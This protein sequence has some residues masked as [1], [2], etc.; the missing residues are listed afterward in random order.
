V[1]IRKGLTS[2]SLIALATA[3]AMGSAN[4]NDVYNAFVD[5]SAETAVVTAGSSSVLIELSQNNNNTVPSA[6]V[7]LSVIGMPIS[8][9]HDYNNGTENVIVDQNA[10]YALASLNIAVIYDDTQPDP[11]D[12]LHLDPIDWNNIDMWTATGSGASAAATISWLQSSDNGSAMTAGITN[13]EIRASSIDLGPGSKQTVN[14][15][16][17]LAQ[18]IGNETINTITGDINPA[19]S[20][21]EGGFAGIS[22]GPTLGNPSTGN[23]VGASAGALIASVQENSLDASSSTID[24]ARIGSQAQ[25]VDNGTISNVFF[26]IARNDIAA[27]ITGNSAVNVVNLDDALDASHTSATILNGSAGVANEQRNTIVGR[28]YLVQVTESEIEAGQT[29]GPGL[30]NLTGSKVNFSGN[31]ITAQGTGNTA[32]NL[33][34]LG[35]GIS[36]DGTFPVGGNIKATRSST[37]LIAGDGTDGN[38]NVIGDLFIANHQ[39]GQLAITGA[40]GGA[41]GAV[42]DA[43]LN[44]MAETVHGTTIDV[45]GN[46]LATTV[47]G[48]NV[49]NTIVVEGAS[50]L[51]SL[52]SLGSAQLLGD[53]SSSTATLN[54]DLLISVATTGG[55]VGTIA[56][57]DITAKG[58]ALHADALGNVAANSVTLDGTTITGSGVDPTGN[59][60]QA[61]HVGLDYRTAADFGMVSGQFTSEAEY[62]SSVTGGITGRFANVVGA[63]GSSIV[64]SRIDVSGNTVSATS[65]A[66]HVTANG[67]AIGADGKTT[68]FAG[69]VGV[70]NAQVAQGSDTKTTDHLTMSATVKATDDTANMAII[71]I[72]ATPDTISGSRI[73]VDGNLVSAQTTANLVDPGANTLS[74][75]ANSVS[76][77]VPSPTNQRSTPTATVYRSLTDAVIP[78]ATPDGLPDTSVQGGFVIVNEQ[79]VEDIIADGKGGTPLESHI[80]SDAINVVVGLES[81]SL[82]TTGTKVSTS[83]NTVLSSVTG[84]RG[85]SS[86]SVDAQTLDATSTL[87]NTQT[88]WNEQGGTS[89]FSGGIDADLKGGIGLSVAGTAGMENVTV[90]ADGNTLAALGQIS[91]AT[92][93]VTVK[94]STQTVVD[95]VTGNNVNSVEMGYASPAG[96]SAGNTLLR[97][98]TGLLNSQEFGA[99]SAT[100]VDVDLI[101]SS[102]TVLVDVGDTNPMND[103]TVT[104]NLNTLSAA[105]KGNDA[106]NTL[107][108][109]V[110]GF[111]LTKAGSATATNGPLAIIANHQRGSEDDAGTGSLSAKISNSWIEMNASFI[112]GANTGS[113][114]SANGNRIDALARV[115][116]AENVLDVSGDLYV[117]AV[118]ATPSV[119]VLDVAA[120]IELSADDL[121]FGI[122]SYQLN[123]VDAS[124]EISFSLISVSAEYTPLISGTTVSTDDN[125]LIAQARG[126][127]VSNKV[128]IAF[129]TTNNLSGFIANLQQTDDG[130]ATLSSTLSASSTYTRS[131]VAG[132]LTGGGVFSVEGNSFIALA[133]ANSAVNS[134]TATGGNLLSG[135]R[136]TTPVAVVNPSVASDVTVA[137]DSSV[138]NVQGAESIVSTQ[139]DIVTAVLNSNSPGASIVTVGDGV[140]KV[141]NNLQLATASIHS[142]INSALLDAGANVGAAGDTASAAV[143]SVQTIT[144]GS[145]VGATATNG[146]FGVLASNIAGAGAARLSLDGNQLAA[147]ARGASASNQLTVKAGASITGGTPAAAPTLGA[148]SQT[149]NADFSVLNVQTGE[150]DVTATAT[151]NTV[152]LNAGSGALNDTV[153]VS[154]NSVAAA[155]TGFVASNGL[156]LNAHAA[157]DASGQVANRQAI[158]AGSIISASAS[159]TIRARIQ[160]GA[161][162]TSA[163]VSGNSLSSSAGGNLAFNALDSAA[164]SSLQQGAGAGSSLDPSTGITMTGADYGVLNGQSVTDA[165]ITASVGSGSI[166]VDNLT[167]ANGSAVVVEGNQIT[168]EAQG[169][170][171]R[172]TLSL[173]TGTFQYPSAAISNLQTTSGATISA[174][175]SNAS[176]GIGNAA[177]FNGSS[178]NS[179][180]IVRGNSIGAT[181]IGNSAVN[182]LSAD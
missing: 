19:F 82:S 182:S 26:D 79:S 2:V 62:V 31:T 27:T 168:A 84:N 1:N 171:A 147:V 54:G 118:A 94:A 86:L 113:T 121:A 45:L 158:V 61:T 151:G 73:T 164:G 93:T 78:N 15:N 7:D 44:V 5:W 172:N 131:F 105:A 157:S 149:V 11:V 175:V 117:E 41:A 39:F 71:D 42:D 9:A 81:T 47:T 97:A 129:G 110:G 136:L 83:G 144:S 28:T 178:T 103:S 92:N 6:V 66:N 65:T 13:S 137:A 101:N 72:A 98:E 51:N 14:D 124:A 21:T 88:F 35:D 63:A 173:D 141:D 55:V 166:L 59:F 162:N 40:I 37:V 119:N 170:Y 17:I 58:N 57:S 133:S 114:L 130:G 22:G 48:N 46:A 125:T 112:Q 176:I 87:V 69:T 165:Q 91:A 36:Q 20:S 152:D 150:T 34:R 24:N 80:N 143:V 180:L 70:I 142:A 146:S 74:I 76:D 107:T 50:T 156:S 29:G 90:H 155:A 85:S 104:A 95:V 64:D 122:A 109:D 177:V 4:A 18:A 167:S 179:S 106:A 140:V 52:V 139:N 30:D 127:Q 60:V 163:Q 153:S 174:S 53:G 43:N 111:D 33:V 68:S 135:T 99:L 56:N 67:F 123:A 161:T 108:L 25:A 75:K 77:A 32:G 148:S 132:N 102:I 23:A 3:S 120:S 89:S 16:T 115:N 169:N 38:T 134:F 100:G 145:S 49:T 159:A 10:I 12:P 128:T 96:F 154:G 116:E 160:G 181:A 138:V 126:N 8:G